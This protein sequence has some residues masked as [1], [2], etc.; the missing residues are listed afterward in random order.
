MGLA[1]AKVTVNRGRGLGLERTAVSLQDA[2]MRQ[3]L[4]CGVL[5]IPGLLAAGPA[6]EMKGAAEALIA[7]VEGAQKKAL[8]APLGDEQRENFRY[9]PRQRS[10][11][12]FKSLDVRQRAAVFTLL[13][14]A[15][16][17][18]G[19]LKS[20]QIM[21]LE[22]VLA[23]L[24][25]RPEFRDPEKYWVSIFGTPGDAKGWGWKFEGHHLSINITVVGDQAA[26]TPSFFGSNPG[27]VR[28]GEHQGLRVLAEEEDVARL[29]AKSLLAEGHKQVAFSDKPPREILT[30]EKRKAD[31]LKPVGMSAEQMDDEWRK[32]LEGLIRVYLERY[33]PQLAEAEWAAI[34]KA[35][36]DQ[37]HFGWAGSLKKGESWYYRVQG[38]TFL[39][40]AANSQNGA[41]H[42]HAVWRKFEGDFGRDLLGDHYHA[43]DH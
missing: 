8:L 27:E 13:K 17:E 18:K 2:A 41:N 9:T 6:A 43:H 26:L 32:Q 22:G 37:V 25:K 20:R 21:M 28:Q 30:G 31:P 11:L 24:E 7:T 40:E 12:L 5:L 33:R 14:S 19:L 3:L 15:M 38:P 29:L 35:G 34:R 4:A 16:S 42:V 39:M 23:K 10:G 36:F 1:K